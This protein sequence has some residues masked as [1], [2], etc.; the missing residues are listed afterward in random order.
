MTT[1]RTALV[2]VKRRDRVDGVQCSAGR[3]DV[4][5]LLAVALDVDPAVLV[6]VLDDHDESGPA[7]SEI[8]RGHALASFVA[9]A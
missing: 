6:A 5:A 9:L 1:I 7:T 8:V 3:D 4:V 2:P